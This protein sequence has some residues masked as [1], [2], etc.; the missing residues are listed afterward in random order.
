MSWEDV[1]VY[2]F[3]MNK[4]SDRFGTMRYRDMAY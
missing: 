3:Q 4:H 2:I 1:I